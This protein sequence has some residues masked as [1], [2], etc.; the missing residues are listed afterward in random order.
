MIVAAVKGDLPGIGDLLDQGAEQRTLAAAVEPD[1]GGDAAAGQVGIDPPE[2]RIAAQL[3]LQIPD[4]DQRRRHFEVSSAGSGM[5]RASR[6]ARIFFSY[7]SA[8]SGN[9]SV[10]W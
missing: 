7:Q 2:D 1:E 8:S 4:A 3:H 10:L 6:F 5:F 9:L